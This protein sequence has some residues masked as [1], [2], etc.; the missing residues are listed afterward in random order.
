MCA[1]ITHLGGQQPRQVDLRHHFAPA[2]ALA[3]VGVV[4]VLD[5]VPELGAALQIRRDHGRPG[6]EA[7]RTAGRPQHAL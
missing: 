5:Q 6:P 7:V 4:V 2:V 3:L 1:N